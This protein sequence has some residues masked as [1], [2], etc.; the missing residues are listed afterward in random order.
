MKGWWKGRLGGM[1]EKGESVKT[2]EEL[3]GDAKLFLFMGEEGKR[4]KGVRG[5]WNWSPKGC[6]GRAAEKRK[7]SPVTLSLWKDGGG[8]GWTFVK[9][10]KLFQSQRVG[11]GGGDREGD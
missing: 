5:E 9:S 1:G 11:R 10:R 8:G 2:E 3:G 6:R 4:K 7:E